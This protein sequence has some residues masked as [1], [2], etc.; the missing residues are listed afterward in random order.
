MCPESQ[1]VAALATQGKV[2]RPVWRAAV[3][4]RRAKLPAAARNTEHYCAANITRNLLKRLQFSIRFLPSACCKSGYSGLY[5][6][7]LYGKPQIPM[8]VGSRFLFEGRSSFTLSSAS[9]VQD[10]T[11]RQTTTACI[12]YFHTMC[13]RNK[14]L[15]FL[16]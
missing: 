2:C 12:S 8:S 3:T 9:K 6:G 16:F 4:A 13:E 11:L 14:D 15:L 1:S 5:R 7:Y 10:N